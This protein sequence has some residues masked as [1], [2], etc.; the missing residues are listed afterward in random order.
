MKLDVVLFGR[1]K[2]GPFFVLLEKRT[3]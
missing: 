3:E 2:S 1:V